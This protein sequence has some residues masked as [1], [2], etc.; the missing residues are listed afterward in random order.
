MVRS[1]REIKQGELP[2]RLELLSSALDEES[3]QESAGTNLAS[4]EGVW[5]CSC[6]QEFGKMEA[7]AGHIARKNNKA[8]HKNLGFGPSLKGAQSRSVTAQSRS[9]HYNLAP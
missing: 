6:G 4:E 1:Q 5:K 3:E 7:I 8:D 9:G 2:P